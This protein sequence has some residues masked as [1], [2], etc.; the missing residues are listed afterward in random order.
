MTTRLHL[1]RLSMRRQL[2]KGKRASPD[3]ARDRPRR[4]FEQTRYV[5]DQEH[6][7]GRRNHGD[8]TGFLDPDHAS[9]SRRSA[10][11]SKTPIACGMSA[12]GVEVTVAP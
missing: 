8:R 5:I 10:Y 12:W 3:P 7:V 9:T 4:G 11:F 2:R 1:A 6:P